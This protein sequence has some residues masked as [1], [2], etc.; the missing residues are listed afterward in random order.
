MDQKIKYYRNLA[1]EFLNSSISLT[2]M[3]EREHTTRQTLAKHF[4]LLGIQIINKQNRI[5]FDNSVFKGRTNWIGS[6]IKTKTGNN[7]NRNA[8]DSYTREMIRK[9]KRISNILSEAT[10]QTIVF[11]DGERYKI[12]EV[13]GFNWGKP[14]DETKT[15]INQI[16]SAIRFP[17]VAGW[18]R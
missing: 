16:N 11:E 17:Y 10:G 13:F 12:P 15:W 14:N 2:K 4:K 18:S 1:D 9:G 8:I 6:K 5:K 3:A 7:R